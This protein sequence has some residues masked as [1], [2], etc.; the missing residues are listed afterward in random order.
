MAAVATGIVPIRLLLWGQITWLQADHWLHLNNAVKGSKGA[1]TPYIVDCATCSAY[2]LSDTK[3]CIH[4]C[5]CK[6]MM[7]T[8]NKCASDMSTNILVPRMMPSGCSYTF[9]RN[10]K[11]WYVVWATLAAPGMLLTQMQFRQGSSCRSTPD[12]LE[13]TPDALEQQPCLARS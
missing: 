1:R 4:V 2:C 8:A 6:P 9:Q 12:A 10:L 13:P 11:Q 7:L 5:C 3:P